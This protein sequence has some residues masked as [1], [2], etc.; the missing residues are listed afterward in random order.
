M[1][2]NVA[3]ALT[4]VALTGGILYG[5]AAFLP[6]TTGLSIAEVRTTVLTTL[7]AVGVISGRHALGRRLRHW[8]GS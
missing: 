1:K 6:S 4:V 7:V 2:W 5:A 8:S 3:A